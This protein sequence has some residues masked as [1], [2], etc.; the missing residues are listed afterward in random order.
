MQRPIQYIVLTALA[1]YLFPL[2]KPKDQISSSVRIAR[3]LLASIAEIGL[4]QGQTVRQTLRHNRQGL[5]LQHKAGKPVRR[6]PILCLALPDASTCA[7]AVGPNSAMAADNPIRSVK[8]VVGH[9]S[10]DTGCE[11]GSREERSTPHLWQLELAYE[12]QLR[13]RVPTPIVL[14]NGNKYSKMSDM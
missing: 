12:N 1:V 13:S 6:V 5:W 9:T 14:R 8:A 10:L 4:I 3:R 2:R 11:E 7:A